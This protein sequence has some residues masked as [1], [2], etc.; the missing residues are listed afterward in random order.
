MNKAEFEEELRAIKHQRKKLKWK[1]YS[2]VIK[3]N[4]YKIGDILKDKETEQDVKVISVRRY[5]GD[6]YLKCKV[7]VDGDVSE[8]IGAEH[9]YML[10]EI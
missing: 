10:N 5:K 8:K 2:E 9:Q 7:I 3:R 4:G 6:L 1:Y